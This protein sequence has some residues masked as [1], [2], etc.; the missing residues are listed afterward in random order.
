MTTSFDTGFAARRRFAGLAAFAAALA[1]LV[2]AATFA[3]VSAATAP[4]A[5]FADDAVIAEAGYI[6]EDG[7]VV[8][9]ADCKSLSEISTAIS[10]YADKGKGGAYVKFTSDVTVKGSDHINVKDGK[11][12]TVYLNG[13]VIDGSQASE[14]AFGCGSG[15]G[16][17]TLIISGTDERGNAVQTKHVGYIDDTKACGKFWKQGTDASKQQ[18]VIEGGLITGFKNGAIQAT[19]SSATI[20]CK[21]VT[22][23]G[24]ST[25]VPVAIR[26]NNCSFELNNS[27]I[28]WNSNST[29]GGGIEV[30]SEK[31]V[32]GVSITLDSSAIMENIGK[33]GGGIS[34]YRA[35]QTHITLKNH[36][37]VSNNLGT[38]NGGGIFLSTHSDV[39]NSL[40]DDGLY[41]DTTSISM[42][43]GSEISGNVTYGYGGGVWG[44][45]AYADGTSVRGKRSITL[46]SGSKIS[47]NQASGEGG[48]LYLE[49]YERTN[50]PQYP[51]MEVTLRNGSEVSNNKA[52]CGGGIYCCGTAWQQVTLSGKSHIDG[53]AATSGNGGALYATSRVMGVSL[54]GESTF[55]NNSATSGGAVYCDSAYEMTMEGASQLNGN[56]ATTGEGGAIATWGAASA[57]IYLTGESQIS[58]NRAYTRG[59]GISFASSG[60][61]FLGHDET[62]DQYDGEDVGGGVVSG[63]SVVATDRETRGGG[64]FCAF[65]MTIRNVEVSKNTMSS[66]RSSGGGIFIENTGVSVL[67]CTVTGNKVTGY[68]GGGI[69][70]DSSG[71]ATRAFLGGKVVVSGNTNGTGDA[72]DVHVGEKN[73]NKSDVENDNNQLNNRI[74]EST[75]L[76][77]ASGS[78]VGLQ[79]WNATSGITKHAMSVRGEQIQADQSYFFSDDPTWSVSKVNNVVWLVNTPGKYQVSVYAGSSTPSTQQAACGATVTLTGSDYASDGVAPDY[80]MLEGVSGATK[81]TPDASGKVTFTMPGNDVTVRA[82][83]PGHPVDD[84]G[85]DKLLTTFPKASV[86]HAA[87]CKDVAVGSV[88]YKLKNGSVRTATVTWDYS[89]VDDTMASGEFTLKGSFTDAAGASHEV[90]QTFSLADLY[91]PEATPDDSIYEG[92]QKVT[93][94]LET[95][96]RSVPGAEI[97]YC[98]KKADGTQPAASDYKLYTESFTVDAAAGDQQVFAYTKVG[99]RRTS[100]DVYDYLFVQKHSVTVTGGKATDAAGKAITSALEGTKVTVTADA[101]AEGKTFKA[102]EV[103]EGDVQLA[104]ASAA[105]TTFV[106]GSKDVKVTATYAA[107]SCSVSFDTH[108]GSDVAA[109]TVEYGATAS[110]PAAPTREGYTFA[111]WYAD[112]ACTQAFDFSKPIKQDAKVY[113]KWAGTVTVV[114]DAAGG[115]AVE[116]AI[117]DEGTSLGSLPTPMRTGYVFNGWYN[118]N[119]RVTG[120]TK[121]SSS[122]V[123]TAHWKPLSMTVRFMDGYS[124]LGMSLVDY[125]SALARPDDPAKTGCSFAGWYTDPSFQNIYDFSKPVQGSFDLFAKYSADTHTVS[126]DAGEGVIVASQAVEYGNVASQPADPVREG[127]AFKGWYADAA[128]TTPFDFEAAITGDTTVYAKWAKLVTVTFD[129]AGG[130]AVDSLTLEAGEALGGLPITTRADYIFVGWYAGATKVNAWA[131]FDADAVLTAKWDQNVYVAQYFDEDGQTLLDIDSVT[132]GGTFSNPTPVREGYTFVSWYVDEACTQEYDFATPAH[133]DVNLYAKWEVKRNLVTFD[134]QGGG[135]INIRQVAYGDTIV[136]PD[137]PERE[138]YV[139]LGWCTDAAGTQEYDFDTPVT[140][141]VKLYAK[142]APK[143]V[144]AFDAAGGSEVGSLVIASGTSIDDLPD[145]TREG[146]YFAGWYQGETPVGVGAT[147][148]SN[149]TLTAHWTP[150]I[151]SVTFVD[152]E[153][154]YDVGLADYASTLARPADPQKDGYTFKGWYTEGGAEYDFTTPVTEDMKLYAHWEAMPDPEPAA[155]FTVTFDTGDGSA[156]AS[157]T[158]VSGGKAT[159]PADPTRDGFTFEYWADSDGNEYDFDTPVTGDLTLHAVWSAADKPVPEP[160]DDTPNS[161]DDSPADGDVP[162]QND[163]KVSPANDDTPAANADDSASGAKASAAKSSA[164]TSAKTGDSV[165][166]PAIAAVAIVAF[167]AVI[168]ALVVRRRRKS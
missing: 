24:N 142:W 148:D 77:M 90:S 109:Q 83:Y 110:Q 12:A 44:R 84:L 163:K 98:V 48:G 97:W 38:A 37:R 82:H 33:E 19:G 23:A 73:S 61:C 86:Y 95:P 99:E 10:T 161:D 14:A 71:A 114:F 7:T 6:N 111:G 58:G 16:S 159:C 129:A 18:E 76:R 155:E 150:S 27:T 138:G 52:T 105:S 2:A 87:A 167:A 88:E 145:S 89:T 39:A 104:D 11:K 17:A 141:P 120:S 154:T 63:N 135:A 94:S 34:A 160:D 117:I 119:D 4:A 47:D 139:F 85:Y 29:Q 41:S 56:T 79:R 156:V 8:K 108:G 130:T 22:I 32:R 75:A 164:A 51:Y 54:S 40:R 78:R 72:A 3:I 35:P 45:V 9:Q 92:S 132:E 124:A 15:S 122:V 136:E 143:I 69:E 59:G 68:N 70:V 42:S 168:A 131:T 151:M 157:Q 80:Y 55:N 91:A 28:K 107:A 49:Y 26:Q 81:L 53:N 112:E 25:K 1:L 74:S 162:D 13:H 133:A 118:G 30:G 121:F 158:V 100:A 146:F 123:L 21:N 113:A 140:A 66:Q 93:L 46:D 125:G 137:Y 96:M 60:E 149:T 36:S 5:A 166:V 67:N 57:K 102:W 116:A 31:Y 43:D 165:P 153:G 65:P 115:E 103:T 50:T 128:C 126:F 20:I 147:F 144:V 64:L 127:Y 101:P 134:T 152:G 62:A 106:V